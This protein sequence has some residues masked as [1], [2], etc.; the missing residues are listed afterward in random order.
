MR[1]VSGHSAIGPCQHLTI[2]TEGSA[3]V[4]VKRPDCFRRVVGVV[5][6]RCGE[7]ETNE[8]ERVK[9]K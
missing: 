8:A 5:Q 9:G 2:S 4:Y 3:D 1:Q 6:A 7:L